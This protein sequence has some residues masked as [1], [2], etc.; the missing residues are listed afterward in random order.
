M[1]TLATTLLLAGAL[2]LP[3]LAC[4][5]TCQNIMEQEPNSFDQPQTAGMIDQGSCLTVSGSITTGYDNFDQHNPNADIDAFAIQVPAGASFQVTFGSLDQT[6]EF[7][8]AFL[9]LQSGNTVEVQCGDWQADGTL[10]CEGMSPSSDLV[11]AFGS[12]VPEDYTISV[13]LDQGSTPTPPLP[14]PGPLGSSVDVSPYASDGSDL[15]DLVN[16]LR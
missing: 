4:N 2:A 14:G 5:P 8:Y 15:L 9:D 16:R 6:D 7:L 3:A 12:R 10:Q 1:K 13:I 11:A